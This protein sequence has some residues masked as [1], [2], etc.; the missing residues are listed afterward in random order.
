MHALFHVFFSNIDAQA[1]WKIRGALIHV[2]ILL[3]GLIPF[4][5]FR[6]KRIV[7]I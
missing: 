3:Q 4:F 1:L 6:R 2:D 7:K 5:R